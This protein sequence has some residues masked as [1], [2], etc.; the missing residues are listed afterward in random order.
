[1]RKNYT[2][3]FLQEVLDQ[4]SEVGT[5]HN[6]FLFTSGYE[7]SNYYVE[8]EKGK[9]VIK[10]F[11]GMDLIPENV[12]FEVEVM[13]YL[14]Q[15]GLKVPKVFRNKSGSLESKIRE[16]LCILMNFVEGQNMV[17]QILTDELVAE[18]GAEAG[19]MDKV[20][21]K[22]TDGSKTRQNY[23]FDLKNTLIL[24]P[25]IKLLPTNFD[26]DL[27]REVL[28]EFRG[29][30]PEL[31]RLPKGL[32]QN[33]IVPHNFLVKDGKLEAIIDFSDLAFSPY[34]QSIAVALHLICFAYNWNP[35][36]AK[37]FISEYLKENPLPK[38]DLSY[39]F[40]LIKARFLSFVLEFNRWNVEYEVDQHR[41]D[42]V[43]DHYNFLKQL[44]NFGEDNFNKLITQI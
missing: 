35:E 19:R 40:I 9:F 38:S 11:E 24:E 15:Q 10:V 4:Y 2:Q 22:F 43:I 23:V 14:Y 44:I 36:Q 17:Q 33:D 12:S 1:M 39:L 3:E 27:L 13:D 31:D 32:M 21:R 37:I 6:F 30:K 5:I 18:A 42:T 25:S 20:L 29:I 26:T 34:V 28:E 8:T 7:N 41:V 16:K